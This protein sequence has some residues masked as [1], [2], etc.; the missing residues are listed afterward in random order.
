MEAGKQLT[1]WK[2]SQQTK[3]KKSH[4]TQQWKKYSSKTTGTTEPR[5]TWNWR[6]ELPLKMVLE[7]G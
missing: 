7:R 4:I 3:K 2:V 1:T 6:H 5:K